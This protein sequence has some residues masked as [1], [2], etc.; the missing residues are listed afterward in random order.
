MAILCRTNARLTD[1]E[2]LLH[3]AELPFQGA[4]LLDRDAARRLLRQIERR[5]GAPAGETVRVVAL[6]SGWLPVLPEK[7]GEREVVRQTDLARLVSLAEASDGDV[8]DFVADLRRRF[9]SG[10]THARGVHLLT[11]HRS[12]GL[13]FE[14]VFLPRL[15]EKELPAKQARTAAE[16]AEERRLLYVGLTRAKHALWLSWAGKPSRF[17]GE[18][19]VD[20]SRREP[21]SQGEPGSVVARRSWTPLGESLRE[22]RVGRARTDG[23]PPYVVFHDSVLQAIADARPE[24]L[25]ELSQI[26]GV[27]P[28]K[29]ERYGP[30]VLDLL[31]SAAA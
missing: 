13:E 20:L 14:A 17:L 28:A 3:D 21:G 1:F 25:G 22:W 30:E 7:L 31:S 23:V 18:L 29:L 19:G 15:T 9:D 4:S 8:A 11:L 24:T 5:P 6:E 16:I 26:S 10:G 2:E 27:G 12:K